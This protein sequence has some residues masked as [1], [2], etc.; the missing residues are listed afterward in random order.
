MSSKE[1]WAQRSTRYRRNSRGC[2]SS[3]GKLLILS[4]CL[5]TM[6]FASCKT[7][8]YVKPVLVWPE[9]PPLGEYE[10]LEDGSVVTDGEYFRS[11]LIYRTEIWSLQ[12]YYE[13]GI[14]WQ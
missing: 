6:C 3:L 1:S 8:E 11:L 7:V 4:V 13:E 2:K 14:E 10:I 12:K 5:L 9:F